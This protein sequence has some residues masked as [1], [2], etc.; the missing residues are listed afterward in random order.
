MDPMH[1]TWADVAYAFVQNP[2]P[3]VTALGVIG[4]SIFSFF[5]MLLG[6]FNKWH[7]SQQ[8]KAIEVV[9]SDVNSTNAASTVAAKDASTALAVEVKVASDKD[10]D[11]QAGQI[12]ALQAQVDRVNLDPGNSAP[13]Q[14]PIPPRSLP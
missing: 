4:T 5:A 1:K 12:A 14:P 10:H 7:L 11:V 8:D 2:N 13:L 6:A 3:T 9:R